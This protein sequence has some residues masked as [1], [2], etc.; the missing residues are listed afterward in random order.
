MARLAALGSSVA[1]AAAYILYQAGCI[2]L[3]GRAETPRTA[4]RQPP[5]ATTASGATIAESPD[6]FSLTATPANTPTP[7]SQRVL[8]PGSKSAAHVI[9]STA[10]QQPRMLLPGSKSGAIMVDPLPQPVM[11]TL[12]PVPKSDPT[13]P[14]TLL[15]GSKSFIISEL[16]PAT[17][18][19]TQPQRR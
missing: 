5:A 9:T 18:P 11:P 6:G 17:A 1:L 7:P 13:P 19:A 2:H 16:R 15:P 8:L 4:P 3:P 12:S 14:R 10:E